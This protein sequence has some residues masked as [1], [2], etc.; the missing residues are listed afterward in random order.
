LD[1]APDTAIAGAFCLGYVSGI[2]HMHMFAQWSGLSPI[3]CLPENADIGH[4]IRVVL[5]YLRE[6]P[7]H[8]QSDGIMVVT[9]ALREAFPCPARTP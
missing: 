9:T 4:V 7:E 3:F 2:E 1:T 8:Q 6:H 5:S